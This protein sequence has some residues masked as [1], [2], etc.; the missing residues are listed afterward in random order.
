[1]NL[2]ILGAIASYNKS[3]AQFRW[4]TPLIKD[5]QGGSHNMNLLVD[6]PTFTGNWSQATLNAFH[7]A[8]DPGDALGYQ[9]NPNLWCID[10]INQ[11]SGLVIAKDDAGTDFV[12]SPGAAW[13]TRYGWFP[14]T[15][16]H[17][18]GTGHAYSHAAGTW[19]PYLNQTVPTRLRWRDSNGITV[20]RVQLHQASAKYGVSNEANSF[21]TDSQDITV[22]VLNEDL[23]DSI[24]IPKIVPNKVGY[25]PYAVELNEFTYIVHPENLQRFAFS[26]EWS[27]VAD[28]EQNA[29][30]GNFTPT[31]YP[32][33]H[34]S[35][36][37]MVNDS[38]ATISNYPHMNYRVWSGDSG[39][40]T[41]TVI[42]GEVHF[43]GLVSGHS[44]FYYPQG[45]T[46]KTWEWRV[47]KLIELADDYAISLG[48]MSQRTG[49]T[50]TVAT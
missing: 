50:V 1:M 13:R 7:N 26:Q 12:N 42:N 19:G 4:A 10:Y 44:P 29:F 48:R 49:Y 6:E 28:N 41:L 33:N 15:K 20:D 23:P 43:Y 37:Y 35:M 18:V 47:N 11:L 14:I 34:R 24:F 39:T 16:R 8:R 27:L 46:G 32:S 9:I 30:W 45:Y 25:R 38:L 36:L 3:N 17:V 40:P 31:L 5:I 2:S 21:G 22:A